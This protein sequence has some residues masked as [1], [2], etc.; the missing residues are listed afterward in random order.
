MKD[1]IIILFLIEN[2]IKVNLKIEGES[3][4]KV[5]L[6]CFL[7]GRKGEKQKNL[8]CVSSGKDWPSINHI[9]N[10]AFDFIKFLCHIREK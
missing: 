5:T 8:G 9:V 10:L 1:R 2:Q 6:C 4:N 7:E 3:S